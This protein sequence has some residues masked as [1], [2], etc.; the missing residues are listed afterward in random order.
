MRHNDSANVFRLKRV[1]LF[2][3]GMAALLVAGNVALRVQ[4]TLWSTIMVSVF[5]VVGLTLAAPDRAKELVRT[6]MPLISLLRTGKDR[7]PAPDISPDEETADG[8]EE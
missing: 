5:I 1:G 3:L 2:V 4:P 8:G 7:L 6:V